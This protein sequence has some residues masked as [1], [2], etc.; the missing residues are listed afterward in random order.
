MTGGSFPQFTEHAMYHY[1]GWGPSWLVFAAIAVVPF[2]RICQRVGYSPWL[3]LLIIVPLANLVFLYYLAFAQW[4][5]EKK[6]P[7]P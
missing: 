4:P 2:W 3:S 5:T 1:H 6:V 7:P